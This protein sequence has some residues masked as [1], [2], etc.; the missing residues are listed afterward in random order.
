VNYL[1]VNTR[2]GAV[3]RRGERIVEGAK[4]AMKGLLPPSLHARLKA[5]LGRPA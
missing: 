3:H 2:R 5:L 4:T 1:F